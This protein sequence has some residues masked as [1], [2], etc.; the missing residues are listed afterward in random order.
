MISPEISLKTFVEKVQI[1]TKRAFCLPVIT[2]KI[3]FFSLLVTH[4]LIASECLFL[5][6]LRIIFEKD[7][8][9]AHKKKD[10]KFSTR[11]EEKQQDVRDL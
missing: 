9:A 5:L 2:L 1:E 11:F 3:L 6:E 7:F 10:K 4:S 8:Q